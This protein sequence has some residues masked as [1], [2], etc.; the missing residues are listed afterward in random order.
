MPR[1]TFDPVLDAAR[2]VL[3]NH[4]RLNVGHYVSRDAR[5][6]LRLLAHTCGMSDTATTLATDA[7]L[8]GLWRI[9]LKSSDSAKRTADK[10]HARLTGTP[11]L[12]SPDGYDT[13]APAPYDLDAAIR[14]ALAPL[15]A[16]MGDALA[17][18]RAEMDTA[19]DAMRVL[20]ADA[21]KVAAR[22][23]LKDM[24]PT[25]LE[26]KLHDAP[27][28]PLGLVH[29]QTERLIRYLSA[30]LNVYL[31]GPAGSGKTSVCEQVAAAFGL[32]A[33]YAAKLSDEFQLLGF[34]QPATPMHPEGVCVRTAFRDAYEFGGV[35]LWD[36]FDASDAN[37]VAALNMAIANKI[38][39]FPD[40]LVRMHPDFHLIAAG[41]TVLTGATEAFQARNQLDGAT[42]NRFVFLQFGYDDELER[43]IAPNADWT[44]YVQALRAAAEERGLTH[45][46]TPRAS[47]DGAKLIAS[48]DTW[49]EAEHAAIWK[50]LDPDTVDTLRHAARHAFK[51]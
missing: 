9:A 41:N 30:G 43:A 40:A 44:T 5:D 35:M 32:R 16:R 31:Y 18:L 39:A 33:F 37:A 46:I 45:P 49:L 27:P 38:C 50:G 23:A 3:H 28:V 24:Q 34:M 13:P 7:D 15:E 8:L 6:A 21:A 1:D 11:R 2:T 4:P 29:K 51:G 14:D 25:R 22:D 10:L 26:V 47:I 20:I 48:G 19:L 42:V 12:P 17:P 36:E